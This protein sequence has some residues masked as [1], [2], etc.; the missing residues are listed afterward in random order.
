MSKENKEIRED[1]PEW[2]FEESKQLIQG[3]SLPVAN[4]FIY[5]ISVYLKKP[6]DIIDNFKKQK[7]SWS[8]HFNTLKECKDKIGKAELELFKVDKPDSYTYITEFEKN[9]DTNLV[10]APSYSKKLS[11]FLIDHVIL[12]NQAFT[13]RRTGR[14]KNTQYEYG[15][16]TE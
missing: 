14:N 3:D 13:L 9:I 1:V 8:I 16:L 7:K 2:L 5:I 11:K 15:L 6:E 10:I 4:G 12:E